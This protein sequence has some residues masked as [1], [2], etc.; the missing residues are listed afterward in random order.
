MF[1]KSNEIL[2]ETLLYSNNMEIWI[3]KGINFENMKQYAQAEKCYKFACN[4]IPNRFYPLY[5]LA[6][7]Y[8]QTNQKEKFI[9]IANI[10]IKKPE[11]VSSYL[12]TAIKSEIQE[13]FYYHNATDSD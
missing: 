6:K 5:K 10:I 11:K 4:M 3:T 9:E 1:E 13:I 8:L 7:L 12:T 2:N